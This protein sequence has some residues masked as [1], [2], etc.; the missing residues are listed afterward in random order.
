[1]AAK[2]TEKKY[3]QEIYQIYHDYEG[4]IQYIQLSLEVLL[5]YHPRAFGPRVMFQQNFLRQLYILYIA[6]I[7]IIYIIHNSQC[8]SALLSSDMDYELYHLIRIIPVSKVSSL[9][10][11][12]TV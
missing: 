6:L 3:T 7:I 10:K 2:V 12:S 4:Y 8:I 1:M 11:S 9:M 5:K